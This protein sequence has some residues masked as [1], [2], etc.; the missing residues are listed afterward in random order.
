[1]TPHIFA[2]FICGILV[3]FEGPIWVSILFRKLQNRKIIKEITPTD[4]DDSRLCKGPH[5]WIKAHAVADQGPIEVS[6]CQVCGF[7]PSTNKMASVEAID[8]IQENNKIRAVEAK[9]YKDFVERE[10]GDIRKY[11]DSE[12]KNGVSFEKLAH[13]HNAGITFGSR[14]NIYKSARAEDIQKELNKSDA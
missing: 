1:M 3:G 11:F 7:I 8:R 13:I 14:Y 10:D 4:V 5:A 12:I 9:I 2:I 6:I